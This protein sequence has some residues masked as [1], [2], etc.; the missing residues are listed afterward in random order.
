M[1]PFLLGKI[2]LIVAVLESNFY[3]EEHGLKNYVF[4]CHELEEAQEY[5]KKD[6]G[7]DVPNEP[8]IAHVFSED[9]DEYGERCVMIDVINVGG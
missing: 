2:M 5:I 9:D 3:T 6:Y 4:F 8:G 1:L 7:I